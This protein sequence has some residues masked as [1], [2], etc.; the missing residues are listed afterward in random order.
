MLREAVDLAK[1]RD[2][3]WDLNPQDPEITRLNALITLIT[4][5]ESKK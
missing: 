2:W 4:L 1:E 5:I 3:L